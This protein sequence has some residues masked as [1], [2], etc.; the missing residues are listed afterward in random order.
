MSVQNSEATNTLNLLQV[1]AKYFR[2]EAEGFTRE[3]FIKLGISPVRKLQFIF[4]SREGFTRAVVGPA[5]KK[6]S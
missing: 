5:E 4:N 3:P 6:H 1:H 2:A